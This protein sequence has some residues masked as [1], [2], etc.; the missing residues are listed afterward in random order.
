MT[1]RP[2]ASFFCVFM[3]K[4]SE[5]KKICYADSIKHSADVLR[6]QKWK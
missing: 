5:G 1:Q 4:K 2:F 3:S 6:Q